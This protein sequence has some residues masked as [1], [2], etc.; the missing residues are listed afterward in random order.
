MKKTFKYTWRV[1]LIFWFQKRKYGHVLSSSL[2]WGKAPNIFLALTKL[3]R[4]ID[5]KNSPI[6]PDLRSLILVRVSQMNGCSFCIDL[7][8][9][10]LLERGVNLDKLH[11]LP[12]WQ[13]STLFTDREKTVLEYTESVTSLKTVE[14]GLKQKMQ[15]LFNSTELVELT[16]LIAFQNMSTK[17]NNAFGIEPQGFCVLDNQSEFNKS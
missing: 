1:R 15:S 13:T 16:A 17:F 5:R 12:A 4:S 7:N 14:I 10:V 3:Y 8:S 2:V 6:A 11:D 9:S